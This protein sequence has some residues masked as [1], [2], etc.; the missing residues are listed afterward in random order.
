MLPCTFYILALNY[1][2][3]IATASGGQIVPTEYTWKF[4]LHTDHMDTVAMGAAEPGLFG[5]PLQVLGVLHT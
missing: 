4:L 2:V 5:R 1:H 3:L